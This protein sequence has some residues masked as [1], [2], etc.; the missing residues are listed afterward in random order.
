MQAGRPRRGWQTGASASIRLG[1]LNVDGEQVQ[2]QAPSDPEV[3][4]WCLLSLLYCSSGS[5][6][7]YAR[8]CA[9]QLKFFLLQKLGIF[10]NADFNH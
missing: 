6:A 3:Y 10:W 5:R 2:L 1:N 8:M 7:I 9:L 4:F